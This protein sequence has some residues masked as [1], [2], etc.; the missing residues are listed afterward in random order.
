[1]RRGPENQQHTLTS[2]VHM[3]DTHSLCSE[4]A[5]WT[6]AGGKQHRMLNENKVRSLALTL[7]KLC[8]VQSSLVCVV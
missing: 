1:M 8:Q 4:A 3:P 2:P 5:W 6:A 7:K